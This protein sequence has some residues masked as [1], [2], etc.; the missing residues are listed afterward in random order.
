MESISSINLNIN[1]FDA[2]SLMLNS[3]ENWQER[4]VFISIKWNP[5]LTRKGVQ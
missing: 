5:Y 1:D 3:H 2:P 4:A